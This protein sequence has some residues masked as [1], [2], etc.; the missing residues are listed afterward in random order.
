MKLVVGLGNPGPRYQAT[1]HNAGFRIVERF[2]SRWKVELGPGRYGGCFGRGRLPAET[3]AALDVGVLQPQGYMNRSGL[4]VV[5][6]LRRLPVDPAGDLLVVFDD[7]DLPFGRLRVRP[8]G[9]SGGHRGLAD[10]IAALGSGDFARL[11]FGVGRPVGPLETADWVLTPFSAEEEKALEERLAAAAD[12]IEC[13]L[14]EGVSAAMNRFNR[15]PAA[16]GKTG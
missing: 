5:E 3:G 12:A 2:A 15:E 1:R 16:D 14:L 9:G 11:R 8:G 13:V 10:V 7:V 6:A 4:A